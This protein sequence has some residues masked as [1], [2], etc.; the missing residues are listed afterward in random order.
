MVILSLQNNL[1]ELWALLNFL[2]PSIF[3][4]SEDFA[5]WFN[6][7]FETVVDTS[8]EQVG[9]ST[10]MSESIHSLNWLFLLLLLYVTFCIPFCIHPLVSLVILCVSCVVLHKDMNIF[11]KIILALN[12]QAFIFGASSYKPLYV[13]MYLGRLYS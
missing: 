9:E 7:P 8:A 6:K 5:Q 4:S 12:A 10:H 3:N 2:L 11:M 13:C 1:E